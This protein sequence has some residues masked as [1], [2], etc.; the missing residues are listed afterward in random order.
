MRMIIATGLASLALALAGCGGGDSNAPTAAEN[1]ELNNAA[2]MLD[3]SADS[4][5][6]EEAPI[7]NGDS[8][9]A[10]PVESNGIDEAVDNAVGN[11][12]PP[13]TTNAQ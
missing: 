6:V 12:A 5:T 2:E 1:E 8:P 10:A 13:E 9:V 4:L 3:T 7:G 11:A